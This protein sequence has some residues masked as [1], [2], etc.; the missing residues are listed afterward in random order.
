MK[1]NYMTMTKT[2]DD[3]NVK[4]ISLLILK[5]LTGLEEIKSWLGL[6]WFGLKQYPFEGSVKFSS[7]S[8]LF[9]LF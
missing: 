8:D 5:I 9:W 6:V 4:H 7:R 2:I 1:Q 3:N